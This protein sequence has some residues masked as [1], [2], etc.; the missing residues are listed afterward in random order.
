MPLAKKKPK[1]QKLPESVRRAAILEAAHKLFNKHG[2]QK[3]RMDDVAALAGLTKGGLYFHFKDKQSLYEA[4]MFDCKD[5]MDQIMADISAQ[6]LPPDQ[7]LSTYM[8][9][10]AQEMA[11][12]FADLEPDGFPG[13]IELFMEGHRLESTRGEVRD[14]YR[15]VRRFMAEVIEKGVKEGVF[16]QKADPEVASVAAVAMWVGIYVQC[17]SDPKA[18]DL[19]EVAGKLCANFLTGLRKRD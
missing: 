18:F 15:R 13:A 9:A 7:M 5:R 8:F 14:F 12:D 16:H 6:N 17:A 3:T 2:F 11:G 19:G 1:R 4:V 10:M